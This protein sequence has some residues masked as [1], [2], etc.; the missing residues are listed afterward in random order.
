MPPQ[1][2]KHIPVNIYVILVIIVAVLT[3]IGTIFSGVGS[4][5]IQNL[6]NGTPES[7]SESTVTNVP[8]S[9]NQDTV[10]ALETQ[11]AL[12]ETVIAQQDKILDGTHTPIL[13]TDQGGTAIPD[14]PQP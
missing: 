5:F 1:E 12:Q 10:S 3:C 7:T 4:S 13:P 2:T 14:N 11:I 8:E 6:R 9:K